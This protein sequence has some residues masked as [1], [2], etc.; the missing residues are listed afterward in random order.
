M[1]STETTQK[2]QRTFQGTVESEKMQKTIV[3]RVDRQARHPKYK[4]RYTI[5]KRYLVHDEN[6]Q[7]HVG[8][9]VRFAETRPLS[10]TKRWRVIGRAV[11]GPQA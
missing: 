9:V 1:E 10:K 11:S 7:Y 3:V 4:K 6:E 2:A 8:D 5:S